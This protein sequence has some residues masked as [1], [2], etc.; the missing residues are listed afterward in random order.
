MIWL[1]WQALVGIH[2]SIGKVLAF[3]EASEDVQE[4]DA[5][6]WFDLGSQINCVHSALE[7][8]RIKQKPNVSCFGLALCLGLFR[9]KL[10][11]L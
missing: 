4:K 5:E 10:L 7:I 1:F 9:L 11:L 8:W 3:L 2:Y 6:I